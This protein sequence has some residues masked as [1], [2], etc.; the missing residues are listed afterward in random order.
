MESLFKPV[1]RSPCETHLAH[2]WWPT[3]C[4]HWHSI[5]LLK[6][7]TF[8]AG[9]ARILSLFFCWVC[10]TLNPASPLIL[11]CLNSDKL[12]DSYFLLWTNIH[13]ELLTKFF[14][15]F[16]I[17]KLLNCFMILKNLQILPSC[18]CRLP[19]SN[20]FQF[21][22]GFVFV[23]TMAHSANAMAVHSCSVLIRFF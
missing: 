9:L 13:P 11:Q 7:T 19:N 17:K 23:L 20:L 3:A 22:L 5:I 12:S 2:Q 8:P 1:Q 4:Q 16:Y 15:E 6:Y 21:Y 14:T 18:S 10:S